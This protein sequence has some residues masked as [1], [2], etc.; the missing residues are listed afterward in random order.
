MCGIF[1]YLGQAPI[2]DVNLLIAEFDK[3]K[4]RGPDNS[5]YV[6]PS[7]DVFMG[8]HRLSIN[9]L[10]ENGNQPFIH[11]NKETTITMICNGEI[12]NY[13]ELI[14]MHK[15]VVKSNSDCEVI[16]LLYEKYG[17]QK[18]IEML[19]GV[20]ACVLHDSKKNQVF[21][22]RDPIGVRALYIGTIDDS[23]AV[24]S[25]LKGIHTLCKDIRQFP[26]GAIWNN[27][28]KTYTKYDHVMSRIQSRNSINDHQFHTDIKTIKQTIKSKLINAVEKRLVSDRPIG[29]LLSGGLDSSLIASILSKLIKLKTTQKTLKTFS[30]G[31]EGSE[32]LKYAKIVSEFLGTDH[33]EVILTEKEML[34]GISDTI[35]QLETYDTT[36]IRAGTPMF[37]L[38]KYIKENDSDGT[39][40]I[41]T[42]EGS[43]EASGSYLYFHNAPNPREFYN[44]T[45]RL[46]EDLHYYDVLRCDKSIA[47]AGLEARVPFLDLNFLEA[48]LNIDPVL[49]MPGCEV[50]GFDNT[51]KIEKYLLRASFDDG[52]FLPKE[53]LWRVKEGMSDGVSSK[54]RGW[55][56]IIQEHANK[57]YS[58]ESFTEHVAKY[59]FNKPAFK[60]ALWFRDLFNQHFPND[61]YDIRA[62]TIPYYWLPKWSGDVV[63][64]SARVLNVYSKKNTL[65]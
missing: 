20:F 5:S 23:Y 35:Y 32:D 7:P 60:E 65:L 56:E 1:S 8:F 34:D 3:I 42:G 41:Y 53:V 2:D 38:S 27:K 18:T 22:A 12:Y 59:T 61:M 47:G 54:S 51:N 46:M 40:V 45:I 48:Y 44:E 13:K 36:T 37:L 19:D 31:L 28:T 16:L 50:S 55:F 62:K 39:T 11:T 49:K 29:C 9:D 26:P 52:T 64:P 17:F 10:S 24:C 14:V 25:E 33:T 57:L 30:V 21:V 6:M 4:H 63:E 58:N 43:D 15:L